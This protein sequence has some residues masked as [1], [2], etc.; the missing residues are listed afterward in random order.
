MT[1]KQLKDKLA[2]MDD[3]LKVYMWIDEAEEGGVVAG[4]G[5]IEGGRAQF[6]YCKSGKPEDVDDEF[7]LIVGHI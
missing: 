5:W 6:P 3:N 1:V 2:K 7:V 4:V